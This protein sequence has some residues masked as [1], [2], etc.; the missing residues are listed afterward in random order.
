MGNHLFSR[1]DDWATGNRIM[2]DFAHRGIVP[3]TSGEL[4]AFEEGR[5]H[6]PV[7]VR[8]RG[9]T[10][11]TVGE[12][13]VHVLRQAGVTRIYGVVGDSLNPFVDAMRSRPW[14]SSPPRPFRTNAVMA[15]RN[16]EAQKN[17]RRSYAQMVTR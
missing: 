13:F 2:C 11:A 7:L 12:Q 4:E 1:A 10:M 16:P 17:F 9:T 8:E 5:E 6:R 3:P 15:R 14:P